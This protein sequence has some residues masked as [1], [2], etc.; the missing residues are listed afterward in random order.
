LGSLC[1]QL[2]QFECF[3][4]HFY[5]LI[6]F[7]GQVQCIILSM[8][9]SSLF[10]VFANTHINNKTVDVSFFTKITKGNDIKSFLVTVQDWRGAWFVPKNVLKNG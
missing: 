2:P 10:N 7:G 1:C 8:S 6:K 9:K 4:I 5:P 3:V